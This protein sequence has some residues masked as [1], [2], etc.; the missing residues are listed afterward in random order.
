MPDLGVNFG[1]GQGYSNCSSLPDGRCDD[2]RGTTRMV[3]IGVV[4]IGGVRSAQ[5]PRCAGF[6]GRTRPFRQERTGLCDSPRPSSS[7]RVEPRPDFPS[8]IA[9]CATTTF[10]RWTLS[11]C[12]PSWPTGFHP[13]QRKP[14][15]AEH[16]GQ[17]RGPHNSDDLHPYRSVEYIRSHQY[18]RTIWNVRRSTRGSRA[19]LLGGLSGEKLRAAVLCTDR[20]AGLLHGPVTVN[21]LTALVQCRKLVTQA[22]AFDEAL[23]SGPALAPAPAGARIAATGVA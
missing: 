13:R 16:L 3:V 23:E 12:S 10:S 8:T 14:A 18:D 21:S 2:Y 6:E 1:A 7:E 11:T 5:A 20:D 22:A 15:R 19:G 17:R 4:S 9:C